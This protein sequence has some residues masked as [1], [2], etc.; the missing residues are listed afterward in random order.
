MHI[1]TGDLVAAD[2]L[3]TRALAIVM[4]D[5]LADTLVARVSKRQVLIIMVMVPVHIMVEWVKITLLRSILVTVRF[6]STVRVLQLPPQAPPQ[7][8]FQRNFPRNH[9][10]NLR[11]LY[12][13]T[14]L[15]LAPPPLPVLLTR[16]PRPLSLLHRVSFQL[17]VRLEHRLQVLQSL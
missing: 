9:L 14:N 6:L 5:Q 17:K 2:W 16:L 11:V 12:R 4:V 10:A 13:L 3:T 8:K 15:Q 7:Q 1:A